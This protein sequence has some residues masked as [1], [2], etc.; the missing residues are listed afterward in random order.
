MSSFREQL[1]SI[2]PDPRGRRWLFV[3]EDQLSDRIG[4]LSRD[5]PSALGVVLVESRWKARRRPYHRQR[6]LTVWANQRH[7]ALEQ[8]ERGVAV[9]H[10]ESDRPYAATLGSLVEDLGRL[11][12][13]EPAERELRA[14]VQPLVDAGALEVVEH[15]G[16]L[17]SPEDF[18]DAVGATPPWRMDRF[19]RY[20]RRKTG[21]LMQ[22]GE[23]VGEKY[24]HDAENRLPWKG[25]PPPPDPPT[26]SGDVVKDELAVWIDREFGDHPGDLD[27]DA[28][29]ATA[30]DARHAW[31]WAR[32]NALPVF[33]PY[34]DAMSTRSSTLFH[35]RSS[36]LMNL[37]RLLPREVLDDVV[38]LDLPLASQEGFVRQV[39]GWRE[40][41]RHVHRETDGFRNLPSGEPGV[42]TQPGDGGWSVWSGADWAGP[43]ADTGP[44]GGARPD[45]FGVGDG[46]FAPAYWGVQ[47]GLAC[48]DHVVDDV[49]R[50]GWSHHITRLMVLGN[51]ATLL[52]FDPRALT[53]WFWVAY[54]DA[55]D[56]VVEPNV[57]GMATYAVG[58]LM[59]TKPYVSGT[60]YIHRM[61]DYCAGCAFDPKKDCPI[62]NLYWA[63]LD[64]HGAHFEGNHRM[65]MPLR[66]AAKREPDKRAEDA[67]VFGFVRS[68]LL[69]GVAV[70]P[71]DLRAVRRREDV[72]R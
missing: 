56:W 51:L 9:R 31:E 5:D 6:L 26:F 24:S 55:W 48:L 17:S 66:S 35:T 18:R 3:N 49:W 59:T 58:G 42:A 43:D 33:G 44:D 52:D 16:W 50:E 67:R 53:D 8:A 61:S 63:F 29:P 10:V 23:P 46:A 22:D 45:L 28:V 70:T 60:P 19:Y 25:D 27:P 54:T 21:I 37:H 1:E 39:L 62:S 38:A 4:P 2:A 41:V 47:S 12:L 13:M 69:D 34:E 57:L 11:T 65:A 32:R 20:L 30:A 72:E 7:F 14:D 36:T 71:D 64:R 40:F 68:R 15:E